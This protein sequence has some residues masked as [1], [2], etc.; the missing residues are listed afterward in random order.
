MQEFENKVV[1]VIGSTSGIG[2]AIAEK[3]A[4]NGA[5]VIITGRR[6]EKGNEITTELKAKGYKAD[7]VKMDVMDIP[8]SEVAID[9]IN[10][11]HGKLD[12]FIYNAG[13]AGYGDLDSQIWDNI[14]TT[15]AKAAYFLGRKAFSYLKD[16]KGV[17][18]YTSS[19]SGIKASCNISEQ[20]GIAY[21]MSK[22]AVN[23]MVSMMA[24]KYAESGVRVNAIAP[25]VT[26]TDILN[27]V[28]AELMNALEQSIP[29]KFA[30][31]PSDMANIAYFLC[32]ESARFITGEVINANGGASIN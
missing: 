18:L 15:N 1:L 22:A 25:G 4:Q 7:F 5:T 32:S 13:I 2:K 9:Q 6:T 16:T 31:E 8:Q 29:L 23:H 20:A 21:G 3:F 30:A 14:M 12:V 26:K 10:A 24:L 17:M 19:M 28:S 27:G 11:K